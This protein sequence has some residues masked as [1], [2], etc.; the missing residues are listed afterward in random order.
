MKISIITATYNSG[1]TLRDTLESIL[2]QT[3]TDYEVLIIDGV[4]HDNT[5]EIVDE[6]MPRF[7]GKLKWH[8]GRDNGLYDAMNKGIALAT[9]DVIGILNSD[10]FYAD[11]TV[12]EDVAKGCAEVDAVYADLDFVDPDDTSR[13]VRQWHGSQYFRGGIPSGMA[14]GASHIL[15]PQGVLREIRRL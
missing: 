14:P 9:G 1:K 2:A 12:L 11:N 10:D 7:D 5:K 13:V 6:F 3:Y 4:S 15:C 8:C